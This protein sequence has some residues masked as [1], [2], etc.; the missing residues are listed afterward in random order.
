MNGPLSSWQSDGL[1]AGWLGLDCQQRQEIFL[2]P[3]VSELSLKHTQPPIQWAPGTFC[4]GMKLAPV[5][6]CGQE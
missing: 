2:Y 5:K 6:C 3:A 1:Q 4:R